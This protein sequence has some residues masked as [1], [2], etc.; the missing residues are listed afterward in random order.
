MDIEFKFKSRRTCVCGQIFR[1]QERE[2]KKSS[3]RGELKFIK[4]RNCGSWIQ[5]PQIATES[6]KSW[7]DSDDYQCASSSKNGTYLDYASNEEN[8]KIE[9]EVRY[10]QDLASL[11]PKK[12]KVLEIGCATGSFLSVLR[13]EGHDVCGIDLSRRFVEEA[14]ARYHLNVCVTDLLDYS[15]KPD[16]FDLVA[17]LGTI[18][19]LQDLPKHLQKIKKLLKDDGIL[20]FNFPF[21]ESWISRL[22]GRRFWMFAPSVSTFFSKKGCRLALENYGLYVEKI[23]LDRQMPTVSKLLGH[24]QLK[25]FYPSAKR[26]GLTTVASPLPVPVPGV[27][28]CWARKHA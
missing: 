18:S 8:R 16:S 20:Y 3:Q 14:K 10:R 12:I 22:Y 11:L 6:L 9:A 4:C 21:C 23:R 26:L 24:G 5:S 17:L 13:D 15:F 19:N 2:L 25:F 28:T 7:Y 27:M 1:E